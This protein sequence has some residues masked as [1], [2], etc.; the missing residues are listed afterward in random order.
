MSFTLPELGQEFYDEV[1]RHCY[2]LIENNYWDRIDN[3]TLKQWLENFKTDE[4]RYLASQ[5]LF[6]FQYRNEKAMI[7]MFKQIIQIY[8]PQ[9]LEELGV[10]NI[11]SISEWETMLKMDKPSKVPFRFSTIDE[12]NKIGKSGHALFRLYVQHNLIN[13]D[14]GCT[15]NTEI[16]LKNSKAIILVD[17]ITGS[18]SQFLGFYKKHQNS[19]NKFEHIIYCPLV[20]HEDA[21]RKIKEENTNIHIIPAEILTKKEHSFYT[22]SDEINSNEDFISFYKE[23]MKRLTTRIPLGFNDQAILYAMNI[24]TPN[25]NLPVIYHDKK[26][27]PLLKR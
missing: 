9:K 7:S 20:A 24:S 4:E 2:S 17:D 27:N 15:I 8:L 23:I 14:I 12:E 3:Y 10:C 5:I 25:N 26:W 22:I 13:K 18:A 11:S 21:I 19:F 1:E 16:K 6:N